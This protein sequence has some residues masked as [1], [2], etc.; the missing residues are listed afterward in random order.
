MSAFAAQYLSSRETWIVYCKRRD[1][2]VGTLS[3]VVLKQ[4][5][6]RM[7]IPFRVA[8]TQHSTQ[9]GTRLWTHDL[10]RLQFVTEVPY[11]NTRT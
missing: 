4:G 1:N 3:W 11:H 8:E 10:K 5:L 2:T 9:N 6:H 7:S